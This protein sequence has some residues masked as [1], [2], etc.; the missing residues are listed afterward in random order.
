[1][2]LFNEEKFN[3]RMIKGLMHSMNRLILGWFSL[4]YEDAKKSR[5]L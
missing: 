4:L 3:A 5:A 1:M 2:L